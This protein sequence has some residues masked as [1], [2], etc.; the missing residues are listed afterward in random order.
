[1]SRERDGG[2]YPPDG[3]RWRVPCKTSVRKQQMTRRSAHL[4]LRMKQQQTAPC[5]RSPNWKW[6]QL[7]NFKE[8]GAYSACFALRVAPFGHPAAKSS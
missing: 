3:H 7:A 4:R 5:S 8:H 2:N 6:F 1:M